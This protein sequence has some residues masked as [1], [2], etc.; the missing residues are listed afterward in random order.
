VHRIWQD[1]I[2]LISSPEV[3]GLGPVDVPLPSFTGK[4]YAALD[5]RRLA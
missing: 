5:N 4:G 3:A 2:R 1:M